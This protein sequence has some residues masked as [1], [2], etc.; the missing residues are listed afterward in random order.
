MNLNFKNCFRC[1]L[2]I[3]SC[4]FQRLF[5]WTR[6]RRVSFYSLPERRNLH[7]RGSRVP[8]HLYVRLDSTKG[9]VIEHFII[10][11]TFFITSSPPILGAFYTMKKICCLLIYNR[12]FLN[13][14]KVESFVKWR[15]ILHVIKCIRNG[16]GK[17]IVLSEW[18]LAQYWEFCNSAKSVSVIHWVWFNASS[19]CV[20]IL[21]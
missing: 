20:L 7:R 6:R 12:L 19:N 21:T 4:P 1:V 18:S 14:V 2:R 17:C 16:G 15:K 8:L 5:L 11:E 10:R 9:G 3:F 13:N